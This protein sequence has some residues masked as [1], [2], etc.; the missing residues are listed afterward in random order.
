MIK[1]LNLKAVGEKITAPFLKTYNSILNKIA[2][3]SNAYKEL[4]AEYNNLLTVNKYLPQIDRFIVTSR[5]NYLFDLF[6]KHGLFSKLNLFDTA[7]VRLSEPTDLIIAENDFEKFRMKEEMRHYSGAGQILTVDEVLDPYT[8]IMLPIERVYLAASIWAKDLLNL[9]NIHYII[10]KE[11]E[12][13]Q[14]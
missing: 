5:T 3:R 9:N 10:E 4:S 8:Q 11:K 6:S 1:T 12:K 7:V 2:K 13:T 14:V